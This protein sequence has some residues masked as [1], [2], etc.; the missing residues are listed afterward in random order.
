MDKKRRSRAEKCG[1]TETERKLSTPIRENAPETGLFCRDCV[2]NSVD[3]VD[4]RFLRGIPHMDGGRVSRC[5]GK[6]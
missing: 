4:S 2:D 1:K 5:P 6:T 3:N